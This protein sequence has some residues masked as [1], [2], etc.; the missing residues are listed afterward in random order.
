MLAIATPPPTALCCATTATTRT[1]H[2]ALVQAA[3][4]VF[5][6]RHELSTETLLLDLYTTNPTSTLAALPD[7]TLRTHIRA[8]ASSDRQGVVMLLL[9]K[10]H[11]VYPDKPRVLQAHYGAALAIAAASR[12]VRTI[13]WLLAP[14]Q[15]AWLDDSMLHNAT[16]SAVSACIDSLHCSS[17]IFACCVHVLEMLM[18]ECGGTIDRD[19]LARGLQRRG[20]KE[21][22]CASAARRY[23]VGVFMGVFCA[24]RCCASS[25]YVFCVMILCCLIHSKYSAHAHSSAHCILTVSPPPPQQEAIAHYNTRHSM[26][27]N[28]ASP[29]PTP[30]S[31]RSTG[32]I[33]CN[34]STQR[35]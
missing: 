29:L 24:E 8:A 15:R 4:T 30:L 23:G 31:S 34:H 16:L 6:Q 18:A 22:A 10:A 3:Y 14:P 17:N 26:V 27:T 13:A 1:S 19:E 32:T 2:T 11:T 33:V 7:K 12:C 5:R 21:K 35:G 20:G 28:T 9:T 25:L